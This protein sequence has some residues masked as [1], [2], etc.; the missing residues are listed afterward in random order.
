MDIP[1]RSFY[2]VGRSIDSLRIQRAQFDTTPAHHPVQQAGTTGN[3]LNCNQSICITQQMCYR[4]LLSLYFSNTNCN[5]SSNSDPES[6]ATP[7]PKYGYTYLLKIAS[8]Q[9]YELM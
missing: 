7:T 8:D 5:S 6:A 9:V 2:C 4:F 1:P 3:T